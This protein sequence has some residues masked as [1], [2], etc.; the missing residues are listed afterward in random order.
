MLGI[1]SPF[2]DDQAG[3]KTAEL[4]KQ[5]CGL[6]T[7]L[8]GILSIEACDRP[9]VNLLALMR[10][11]EK[12]YLIDAV[13]NGGKAGTVYR[14]HNAEIE[15]TT[16]LYSTHAIGIAQTLQLG[17]AL[18][19]LPDDIILYGIEIGAPPSSGHASPE[20]EKGIARIAQDIEDEIMSQGICVT[21]P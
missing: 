20:L 8:P 12:V 17:R 21:V 7:L 19:D 11:A 1:G 2:G 9:G 13:I 10:G 15:E 6:G 3:W 16:C 18:G 5:K 4:L 14:W